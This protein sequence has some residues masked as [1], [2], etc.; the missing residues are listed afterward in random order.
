MWGKAFYCRA[1]FRAHERIHTGEK[2]YECEECGDAFRWSTAFRRHPRVRVRSAGKPFTA[3]LHC[4]HTQP[5][6]A[7]RNPISVNM[8]TVQQ[9]L[10]LLVPCS[11]TEELTPERNPM[12]ARSVGRPCPITRL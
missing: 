3:P 6:T 11:P 1:S 10:Q 8:Y 9:S 5:L 4:E 12:N 7:E 2:P